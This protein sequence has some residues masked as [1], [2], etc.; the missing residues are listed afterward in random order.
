MRGKRFSRLLGVAVLCIALWPAQT[1]LA[2]PKNVIFFIGDGMGENQIDTAAMYNGGALSFE[3]FPYQGWLSTHSAD[4]SVTDSAAAGTALATGTKVNNGVISMAYPGDHG[5]LQTLLEYYRDRGASTGL[6]TTTYMTHATP[7]TFGAHNPSRNNLTDIA[8][9]Y[10]NQTVPNVLFGG[11]ANGMSVSSAQAAGYTVVTDRAGMQVLSPGTDNLASGQFGST[12][13]PY[14]YDGLGSLP[15]LS[16]MTETALALLEN[17]PDGFFLMVEG[18]R[19]DHACHANDI[20]RSV[21]ETLAFDNAVQEAVAWSLGR[22]DTLILVTADHET[23]GLM[24]ILDN[25]AGNFPLVSWST[26]GHTADNVP[27]Y[28]WGVNAQLISGMMDNTDLFY[29]VTIPEPATLTL[30]AL[31][32]GSAVFLR[33]RLRG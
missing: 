3:G 24:V 22:T 14:E 7:A 18:G 19:I 12:H 27:V 11:G 21:F 33:R 8:Y 5:E 31:G 17:D 25:G 10:L 20:R 6:V 30:L 4:S 26:T 15:H 32:L 2:Q 1:V 28:A 23:G 9:D 29:V 13:L 16:E